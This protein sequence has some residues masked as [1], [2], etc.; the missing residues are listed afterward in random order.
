MNLWTNWAPAE[1]PVIWY[2]STVV[3]VEAIIWSNNGSIIE[4]D[5]SSS[6]LIVA[7]DG[8]SPSIKTFPRLYPSPPEKSVSLILGAT[9]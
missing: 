6:E 2:V 4:N 3:S 9:T 5:H 7:S 8:L 1:N